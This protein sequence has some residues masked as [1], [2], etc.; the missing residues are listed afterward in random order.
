MRKRVA[1]QQAVATSFPAR[2]LNG[3]IV[4]VSLLE[5][6]AC[7]YCWRLCLLQYWFCVHGTCKDMG[8]LF[9]SGR[10][11]ENEPRRERGAWGALGEQIIHYTAGLPCL[12]EM[13]EI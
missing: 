6:T 13:S 3:V 2:L 4:V 7:Q 8:Y 9:S 1:Y 12:R 5:R 10:V 11:R